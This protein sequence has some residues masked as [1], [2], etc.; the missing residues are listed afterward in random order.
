MLLKICD[1]KLKIFFF[2]GAKNPGA[3]A[4]KK[5]T[6]SATLSASLFYDLPTS[7]FIRCNVSHPQFKTLLRILLDPIIFFV[8]I[9]GDE[10]AHMCR[11]KEK[12]SCTAVSGLI[13]AKFSGIKGLYIC[14]QEQKSELA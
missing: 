7:I 10:K 1:K 9:I 6:G 2:Y 8:P 3:G 14:F 5:A 4:V 13:L 11:Q 12:N